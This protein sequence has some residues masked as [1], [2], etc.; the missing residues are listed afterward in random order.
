MKIVKL[1]AGGL[2]V[3]ATYHVGKL[4]GGF[5]VAKVAIDILEEECP[6]IKKY[7]TKCACEKVIDHIFD[8]PE[9]EGSQ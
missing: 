3:L 5:K 9:E 6:G 1:I 4:V 2:V 8:K 7:T